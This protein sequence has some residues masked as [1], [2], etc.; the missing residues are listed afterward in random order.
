MYDYFSPIT[1]IRFIEDNRIMVN[2]NVDINELFTY[3]RAYKQC[4]IG[5]YKPFSTMIRLDDHSAAYKSIRDHALALVHIKAAFPEMNT[6]EVNGSNL[7]VVYTAVL[8]EWL[9][10]NNPDE[11]KD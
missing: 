11:L 2:R 4:D 9:E 5:E 3:Y 6:D 1:A 8:R 7:S 10:V